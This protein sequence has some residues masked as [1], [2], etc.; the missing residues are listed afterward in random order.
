MALFGRKKTPAKPEKKP[1]AAAAE[2]AV[3]E[4]VLVSD[5]AVVA[6]ESA[7]PVVEKVIKKK[8]K[9]KK[10]GFNFF[11]SD[12]PGEKP[13]ANSDL[14]AQRYRRLGKRI[15]IQSALI[16]VLVVM[17]GLGTQLFAN[18]YTYYARRIGAPLGAE[19]RLMELNLPIVNT[20]S[21][22]A[23]SMATVT[24][25][26]T[27]N[28]ANYNARISM[29]GG[30]F[31]PE[32]WVNFVKAVSKSNVIE[33]FTTQQLVSTAAP[34]APAT[35]EWEGENPDTLEYE[36]RVKVPMIRKFVTNNDKSSITRSTV[37]LTIIRMPLGDY[38]A[39]IA[40]KVWR[41]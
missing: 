21:I 5:D 34:L 20:E 22:L 14:E 23:W 25:V 32:G 38:P 9:S 26:L 41:E 35:I 17:F 28:F 31:H 33:G 8:V 37:R 36:W 4:V 40:I 29:F 18:T 24:E 12:T 7:T 27:F 15:Q 2:A 10:K 39:G 1:V 6:D 19:K 13:L 16:G 3:T 11:A 30:R